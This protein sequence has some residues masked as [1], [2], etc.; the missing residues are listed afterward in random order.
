[1]DGY[2]EAQQVAERAGVSRETIW[3]YRR[4]GDIPEPDEYAGRTPLWREETITEWLASRPGQG[5]RAGQTAQRP[6]D[7]S[8]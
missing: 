6:E 3:R 1:M 8:A 4:R 5:W 2:L 7:G